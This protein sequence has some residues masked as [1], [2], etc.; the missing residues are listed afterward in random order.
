MDTKWPKGTGLRAK[1]QGQ[2]PK[3]NGP[4]ANTYLLQ[5]EHDVD[6]EDGEEPNYNDYGWYQYWLL[7]SQHILKYFENER[8]CDP[9][10]CLPLFLASQVR[11]HI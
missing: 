6:D 1:A 8:L 2:R 10:H 11:L 7:Q 5:L 4:R 9:H 3:G